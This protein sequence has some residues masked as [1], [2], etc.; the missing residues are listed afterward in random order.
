MNRS[1]FFSIVGLVGFFVILLGLF[2]W[3]HFLQSRN[4]LD[5]A[6]AEDEIARDQ[7]P[8]PSTLKLPPLRVTDPSRGST[9]TDALVVVE[10]GD[11][12]SLFCRMAEPEIRRAMKA[13]PTQA[14]LVWRDLPLNADQP[15]GV[16]P[17]LAARCAQDQGKFWEMHDALFATAKLDKAGVQNAAQ[18]AGLDVNLFTNCLNANTHVAELRTDIKTASDSAITSPPT[19]FIGKNALTGVIK[20]Q[21]LADLIAQVLSPTPLPTRP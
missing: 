9:S 3:S 8:P 4:F 13:F 19:L 20:A 7:A 15:D 17:A 6:A 18:S 12:N 14:R 1:P 11:Y 2:T 21:D 16:L 5:P 10:Y